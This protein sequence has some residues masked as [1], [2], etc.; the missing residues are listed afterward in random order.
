MRGSDSAFTAVNNNRMIMVDN[1]LNC[2]EMSKSL[3]S[4]CIKL[5]SGE[6]DSFGLVFSVSIMSGIQEDS[7]S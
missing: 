4:Q 2:S 7:L 1:A 6:R 5:D 3:L